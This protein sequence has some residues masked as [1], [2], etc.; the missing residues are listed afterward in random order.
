MSISLGKRHG[1]TQCATQKGSFAILALDHRNNLRRA[2]N[3]DHPEAVSDGEMICFK[4]DVLRTVAPHFSGVLLD[5][6]MGAPQSIASDA[7][8]GSAGLIVAL[9]ATG[10]SGDP[11]APLSHVLEDWSVG[12]IQRMGASAV[13]LL[14]YYHPDSQEASHQEALVREVGERC[15][16]FD[17]AF[18]LEPLSFSL[19]VNRKLSSQEKR[20]VVLETAHILTPLGVDV[21]KAEFPIIIDDET[22][23]SV[24]AEACRELT[25]KSLTPWVLLSAGVNYEDFLKQATVAMES[26][27]SGVLAGRAIWGEAVEYQGTDR[28]KFLQEVA[29]ER[30]SILLDKCD[31][32]A[33]PWTEAHPPRQIDAD[34]YKTYADF[35]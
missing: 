13:K 23:E 25:I 32:L 18:F 30:M 34:W 31:A 9:E 24:W 35:I 12:K 8:P 6:E 17:I 20:D 29:A 27:A 7:L 5:P 33:K 10:Y 28:S 15:K 16:Q 22:D 19:D 4:Q 3:P 1:L 26:G 21:L 11:S 14:I 2:L